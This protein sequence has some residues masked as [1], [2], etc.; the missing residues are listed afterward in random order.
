MPRPIKTT[1]G[2]SF[3]AE[4]DW[5]DDDVRAEIKR[6]KAQQVQPAAATAPPAVPAPTQN[7]LM[8]ILQAMGMPTQQQVEGIL[9]AGGAT[10]GALAGAPAGPPGMIAGAA[11]GGTGGEAWR[12]NLASMRGQGPQTG[13]EAL[14]RILGAGAEQAAY[15]GTGLGVAKGAAKLIAKPLMAKALR[16]AKELV[17]NFR[18]VV[19]DALKE[20]VPVGGV[21]GVLG[22]EKATMLRKTATQTVKGILNVAADRGIMFDRYELAKPAIEA[23][24]TKLGRSLTELENAKIVRMVSQRAGSL[25][26]QGTMGIR[27]AAIQA[28]PVLAN[29]IR[30]LAREE[31]KIAMKG[32]AMGL[33]PS[34]IPDLD[35]HI[36]QGA[37]EALN[38]YVA[39]YQPA[40]AQAAQ[41][42][43]LER[44]V[45][46]AELRPT[47]SNVALGAGG[48]HVGL[49]VPPELASRIALLAS[50][51]A[52]AP[53]L[54][55][56]LRTAGLG[57]RQAFEPGV[58]P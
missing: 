10:L 6:L 38:R 35:A 34:A 22:S 41:A 42:I 31:A 29:E 39:G 17:A 21:G 23:I 14:L 55:N 43:G 58:Q 15:E 52:I 24:E 7:P 40:Q 32:R 27:R 47:P 30:R 57:A 8:G 26:T 2:I 20:R 28:N 5:T 33:P 4:D 16:P 44:A 45:K 25:L 53:L 50:D 46:A 48:F 49:G 1:S 18:N 9:P 37:R 54:T 51:P 12:Q 11:L 3:M 36:E 56:L 19:A 13:D